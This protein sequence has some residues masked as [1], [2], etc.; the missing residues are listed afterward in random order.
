MDVTANRVWIKAQF[1]DWWISAEEEE[2]SNTAGKVA[3]SQALM[4]M[5]AEVRRS[6][7]MDEWRKQLS[8]CQSAVSASYLIS[9]RQTWTFL[10]HFDCDSGSLITLHA[11]RLQIAMQEH[12]PPQFSSI[13][14]SGEQSNIC[15]CVMLRIYLQNE[16]EMRARYS[17]HRV[18]C[19]PGVKCDEPAA[20]GSISRRCV[21]L[22]WWVNDTDDLPFSTPKKKK[23]KVVAQ[24]RRKRQD[25]G[26]SVLSHCCCH[27]SN[28]SFKVCSL[29]ST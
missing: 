3:E 13:S 14:A 25:T 20:A 9:E 26:S 12:A 27:R 19:I 7:W 18:M 23:K 28:I 22:H 1:H 15:R 24:S 5:K 21:R 17:A 2:G 11:A 6:R 29:R 8:H 16:G 10:N 4:R